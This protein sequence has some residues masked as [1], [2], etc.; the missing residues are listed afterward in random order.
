MSNSKQFPN[1]TIIDNIHQS[2]IDLQLDP[3]QNDIQNLLNRSLSYLDKN[4]D[5]QELNELINLIFSCISNIQD[6]NDYINQI[7][8]NSKKNSNRLIVLSLLL[9]KIKELQAY[10][11]SR[12]LINEILEQIAKQIKNPKDKFKIFNIEIGNNYIS[13]F[14]ADIII[15]VKM[16]EKIA[17][18]FFPYIFSQKNLS[19]KR[20]IKII[21]KACSTKYVSFLPETLLTEKRIFDLFSQENLSLII[22]KTTKQTFLKILPYIKENFSKLEI[23]KESFALSILEKCSEHNISYV[24]IYQMNQIFNSLDSSVIKYSVFDYLQKIK[25]NLFDKFSSKIND[26]PVNP[27]ILKDIPNIAKIPLNIIIQCLPHIDDIQVFENVSNINLN[28]TND[29]K[30]GICSNKKFWIHV[31]T[32]ISN[33]N[34]KYSKNLII[35]MAALFMKNN[36]SKD[37]YEIFDAMIFEKFPTNHFGNIF[38][39]DLLNELGNEYKSNFKENNNNLM[40]KV[41]C[42]KCV[43]LSSFWVLFDSDYSYKFIN[44]ES[45]NSIICGLISPNHIKSLTIQSAINE[46]NQFLLVDALKICDF[47]KLKNLDD[48]M[49]QFLSNISIYIN[50]KEKGE[51]SNLNI[52]SIFPFLAVSLIYLNESEGN[53]LID[54]IEFRNILLQSCE[55]SSENN[56]PLI[57]ESINLIVSLTHCIFDQFLFPAEIAF[58]MMNIFINQFIDNK[59]RAD[60][61]ILLMSIFRLQK[62]IS[63]LNVQCL[64][65]KNGIKIIKFII[66]NISNIANLD[67]LKS[68]KFDLSIIN[69]NL[70]VSFLDEIFSSS[71]MRSYTINCI[72][73]LENF[74]INVPKKI[75]FD[76]NNIKKILQ[77]SFERNDFETLSLVFNFSIKNVSLTN[78]KE[79]FS[80]FQITN[81]NLDSILKPFF[82]DTLQTSQNV[83]CEIMFN[84]LMKDS[85]IMIDYFTV[86]LDMINKNHIINPK[87]I[88][89]HYS[90][91]YT[92][93]EQYFL[94]AIQRSYA[95]H[96][97]QKIF[98]KKITV[99]QLTY[100]KSSYLIITKL[101]NEANSYENDYQALVVLKYIAYHFPFIFDKNPE[102]IFSTVLPKLTSFSLLF[103]NSIETNIQSIKTCL[104]A[105]SFLFSTL[106]SIHVLELFIHWI[107]N[108]IAS[109]DS[110][111]ILSFTFILSSLFKT[112][113]V[114]NVMLSLMIKNNFP[115]IAFQLLDK[116]VPD[117]ISNV[118]KENIFK[119]LIEY[120]KKLNKLQHNKKLIMIDELVNSQNPFK[121]MFGS[122]IT[123]HP[124][125][126]HPLNYLETNNEEI[127]KFFE[128]IN[129]L[130]KSDNICKCQADINYKT[131]FSNF[132]K[133]EIKNVDKLKKLTI[134]KINT[135]KGIR[136]CSKK[137]EW[138]Y[139]YLVKNKKFTLLH[140]HHDILLKTIREID[141]LK[142]D[143]R[144]KKEKNYD[145]IDV[146]YFFLDDFCQQN[147]FNLIIKEI[148][149]NGNNLCVQLLKE[150]TQNKV[151]SHSLFDCINIFISN[152]SDKIESIKHLIKILDDA[153]I[154]P[155][156]L[157]DLCAIK[158][159]DFA[160]MP[161][162]RKD[163]NFISVVIKSISVLDKIPNRATHL[164]ALS[165]LKDHKRDIQSILKIC[166]T[167][168]QKNLENIKQVLIIIIKEYLKN[169]SESKE[170]IQSFMEIMPAF[171][172]MDLSFASLIIDKFIKQYVNGEKSIDK[173]IDIFNAI[174][175]KRDENNEID[176]SFDKSVYN[177]N[178]KWY[179]S[180]IKPAPQNLIEKN[181]LF[182]KLYDKYHNF[183]SDIL[184]KDINN[185]TKFEFLVEYP[186]LTDFEY[187]LSYFKKCM[188]EKIIKKQKRYYVDRHKILISTYEKLNNLSKTE[189]LHNIK[190]NF[191]NEEG[192]DAGGLTKEWFSL[193]TQ[194]LF[195]PNFAL[196]YLTENNCYQPSRSSGINKE[197]IDYF[198][199][200]GKFVARALIQGQYINAHFTSSFRRLILHNSLKLKDMQDVDNE[201]YQSMKHILEDD[202]LPDLCFAIDYEEF[203]EF[204]TFL[205]KENG[206][207]IDVTN[208]NKKEYVNLYIN[209]KLRDSISEQVNAFLEGFNWLIPLN[210]IRMFTQ[211]ELDLLICGIPEIDI[212]DMR[213]NT[214]YLDPYHNNHPV[215]NMFFNVLSKWNS[216]DL[217][218]FLLFLTGSSQV[219]LHGF[220]GYEEMGNPIKI[221][222]RSGKTSLCVAHT[223]FNKLDLP[224]YENEE[225]MNSKLLRA[226]IECEF[227]IS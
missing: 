121:I 153:G 132:Q 69:Q 171:V 188:A 2:I 147:I 122:Y 124:I 76:S 59:Y 157:F 83:L 87:N 48:E 207:N 47:T 45:S 197:H 56:S 172:P 17:S 70:L 43:P 63:N 201:I 178:E 93:N 97:E 46:S 160:L 167:M 209:Y 126:L 8:E 159:I 15:I 169:E 112:K 176:F 114:K 140:E 3:Q 221:G 4:I 103:T 36:K 154:I 67:K 158:L 195:N 18:K 192:I 200:A 28:S 219:P 104:L 187:R 166:E 78:T 37:C 135:I 211:S 150:I 115:D 72:D 68:I 131:F 65:D 33:S 96:S 137:H 170:I 90:E 117:E 29:F 223:C 94:K 58:E 39:L 106:Y 123:L 11:N 60:K 130:E 217:A 1:S 161:E 212:N 101:F 20:K 73:F 206:E 66:Q 134:P 145:E 49:M 116:E 31:F 142:Y 12:Q 26:Y 41:I 216:K 98:I 80:N 52:N 129:C 81:T 64:F 224:E 77:K 227:A 57:I 119:L 182:W 196:F 222:Y 71:A 16:T 189:W 105:Q 213:A 193:V 146:D 136:I 191:N 181:P 27:S 107:L 110:S 38:L 173:I 79:L 194:E 30:N 125:K 204:K 13:N 50:Q 34:Q 148:D 44:D 92:N 133:F 32:V 151:A 156:K 198:R 9:Q 109:F 203:G 127:N 55:L 174:T 24:Y 215:I 111:Q 190:I 138:V 19:Q 85:S 84:L 163:F 40:K 22:P 177:S 225:I 5:Q 186:E 86:L 164:I 35:F 108:N 180:D 62:E 149:I 202:N 155:N 74:C 205:L 6:K 210:E 179:F 88:F 199:F 143:Y 51:L 218:K 91:E 226:I 100:S 21:Q 208:E 82:K 139:Q 95:I 141:S 214:I 118:Y 220:K 7:Y 61:T 99:D 128:K 165:L 144:N 152:N 10:P 162:N 53:M 183:I 102:K 54:S 25:M 14:I 184:R 89:K 168:G 75:N 23:W 42:L 113:K 120:Y 175:P 185:L